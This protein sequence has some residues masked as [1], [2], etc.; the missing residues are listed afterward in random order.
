MELFV[1]NVKEKLSVPISCEVFKCFF[2]KMTAFDFEY[3]FLHS[4]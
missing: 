3:Y 1:S 4:F 2:C